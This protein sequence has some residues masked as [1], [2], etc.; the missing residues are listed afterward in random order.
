MP[1][2]IPIVERHC[3]EDVLKVER[4]LACRLASSRQ[5]GEIVEFCLEAA[6]ANSGLECGGISTIDPGSGKLR[7]ACHRGLGREF[8]EAVGSVE[9]GSALEDLL[10]RG[11]PVAISRGQMAEHGLKPAVR[12]GLRLI[13]ALPVIHEG[14]AVAC[15]TLASRMRTA[16]SAS[17]R[18][19]LE[20]VAAQM[21]GAIARAQGEAKLR[22]SE[23][24]YRSL[25]D[26]MTEGF[27]LHEILCDER[28]EPCDYVFLDVNPSFEQLTGLKREEVIGKRMLEVLPEEDPA[29][30]IVYGR[31]ALGGEPVRFESYSPALDRHY[32]VF[33]YCPTPRRFAVIFADITDR[34][35]M[36][37][38][39]LEM[40]R[41][42]LHAQK[43]ESLGILAGGIAHD[44][45]NILAGIAGYA[46]VAQQRLAPS[47]P[48]RSDIEVIQKG[49]QRAAELTRQMLAYSG[50]G[51]GVVGPVN[52]SR[53]V[54]DA[55]KIVAVS[56]SKK[57]ALSYTRAPNLPAVRADESQIH[58]VVLNLVSNASE[59]IG[60]GPGQIRV[61]ADAS[62]LT[63][64][65][66]AALD[67]DGRLR[68]GPYVRLTVTDTGCGMD[69]DTLPRIFDPFF[70]TK[71]TGRGLGL[72]AV[73][74]IVRSHGG[75]IQVTSRPGEGSTFRVYLPAC[76]APGAPAESVARALAA[77]RPASGVLLIV[78]D[79]EMVRNSARRMAE[80]AGYS[81]LTAADGE[82]ALEVCG[83]H[84]KSI[85]CVLLDLTM[86]KMDGAETF[87]ELR[88]IAPEVPVVLSSG[89]SEEG[90]A[91]RFTGWGLSG[92]LHK[93]YQ[94]E[95]LIAALGQATAGA[96][97]AIGGRTVLIVDDD[98]GARMSA[99][100]LFEQAGFPVLAAAGG[101]EAL[102]LYRERGEQIACVFVD[103][104]MPGMDGVETLR[105]LRGLG[106]K[107][108]AIVS[109]G[110]GAE[111][112]AER[113]A[114][115]DVLRFVRKPEPLAGAIGA[116]RE[117]LQD[118]RDSS[119]RSE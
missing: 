72:A 82:E 5:L 35:R 61:A 92:F 3:A 38:E 75:A 89:Y 8:L 110:Y 98:E 91:G 51:K 97:G 112:L 22:E 116:L 52:L 107:C 45:N 18:L 74:G 54:E 90:V 24:R 83:R 102:G 13:V 117:A 36:E 67:K 31:V 111:A 85:A 34:K 20:A 70:T 10:G 16:I 64:S 53:V 15:L 43:L 80:A 68:P 119:L 6:I 66:C 4:D 81:V 95:T 19:S 60:E 25:F 108:H 29:W 27:A 26:K 55:Q 104:T 48:V 44:F 113:F 86:P 62:D 87:R 7:V 79:E 30:V 21:G 105:A 59:A 28:G 99:Q 37:K 101:E 65:D 115:L 84:A 50:Q 63:S 12:E 42:L 100:L 56:V 33:A 88:R 76:E 17:A 114:D 93:P 94:Y 96:C 39:K 11:M 103:L 58:Q 2:A 1:P 118:R 46:D 109:S 71:F 78:D 106:A 14:K 40:E 69:E 47:D 49:V 77:A 9:A 57:A 32:A 73:D 23:E 41:R